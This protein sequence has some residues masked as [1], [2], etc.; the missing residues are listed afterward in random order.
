MIEILNRHTKV[1]LY[2][3]ETAQS[4]GEALEE[5][6]RDGADLTGAYLAGADLTRAYLTR[7][8]LTG[9]NL[10]RANLTR[11]YLTRADLTGADLTG[12]YG[13]NPNLC[14]PLRMLR[15]QPGQIRA[16]KLV[17]EN[18]QS[19]IQPSQGGPTLTYE[20]GSGVVVDNASDDETEPCAAGVNVASLDWCLRNWRG[21]RRILVVEFTADDIAAIPLGT[22][23]KFRVHRCKVV[24]ELP[25]SEWGEG[26]WAKEEMEEDQ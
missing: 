21:K 1:V 15:D 24:R 13:I 10:A 22:D 18:L 9:A 26:P 20:I 14:D 11:A 4:I 6:E 16:Y 19:P 12:A 23:G 7:A 5:A 25:R 8:D 3:S 17:D 2:T